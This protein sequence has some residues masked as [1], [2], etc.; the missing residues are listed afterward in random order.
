[1]KCPNDDGDCNC[2]YE[3]FSMDA[4]DDCIDAYDDSETAVSVDYEKR[5]MSTLQQLKGMIDNYRKKM[6]TKSWTC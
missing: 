3:D 1:M 4:M 5:A 2:L 6:H